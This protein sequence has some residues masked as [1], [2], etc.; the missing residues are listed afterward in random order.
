MR[1]FVHVDPDG[2]TAILKHARVHIGA[3]DAGAHLAQFCGAGDTGYL[4]ARWVR[5]LKA[6]TLEEAVHRL[7]GQLA[8]AFGIRGRGRIAP[9]LAGDLV[10]FDPERIDR[11]DEEFVND[12]PGGGSRYVRHAQGIDAVVVNGA[13]VWENDA[14]TDARAGVIV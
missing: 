2:V 13:V 5:D 3:S 11:G 6:F 7:T 14:Y 8:D 10:L 4:L 12:L 9:G 1:N